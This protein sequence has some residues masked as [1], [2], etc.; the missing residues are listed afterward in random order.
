MIDIAA[1][2]LQIAFAVAVAWVA[3]EI[4]VLAADIRRAFAA[5]RQADPSPIEDDVD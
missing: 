3:F 2:S 5:R 4:V 1:L